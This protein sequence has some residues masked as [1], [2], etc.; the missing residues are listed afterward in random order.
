MF[1]LVLIMSM[2]LII[3]SSA[4]SNDSNG[5][6]SHHHQYCSEGKLYWQNSCSEFEELISECAC[7][8]AEGNSACKTGCTD[9]APDCGTRQ[10]G[11]DGCN[12]S[13]GT[14]G[15][16]LFCSPLDWTCKTESECVTQS[17]KGCYPDVGEGA[18][19]RWFDSCGRAEGIIE[20]C[21]DVHGQCFLD[22]EDRPTCGCFNHWMPM[23]GLEDCDYCP[24]NW[25][26]EQDCNGCIGN[27]DIESNCQT[28][29]GNWSLYHDCTECKNN[30]IDDNNNCGTCPGN[31]DAQ[32]DCAT[33]LGNWDIDQD[34]TV[35]TG[36]WDLAKNCEACS[37]NLDIASNCNTCLKEWFGKH[38]EIPDCDYEEQGCVTIEAGEPGN[39]PPDGELYHLQVVAD[40][41]A[42]F[43]KGQII[44][45][46]VNEGTLNGAETVWFAITVNVES[47]L[48]IVMEMEGVDSIPYYVLFTGDLNE[49]YDYIREKYTF[50]E[51][52]LTY[53]FVADP[54]TVY[55]LAYVKYDGLPGPTNYKITLSAVT[56][57]PS[58]CVKDCE[59]KQ[60][61]SDGCDDTCGQCDE[62]L[63]CSPLDWTCKTESECVTHSY[64][65]CY[66][67]IGEGSDIRWFDSCGRP[68][69]II[70]DC[71]DV[72]GQCYLY[73]NDQPTCGCI[74]H[75]DENFDCETCLP[76]WMGDDCNQ[77]VPGSKKM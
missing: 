34:C 75:W 58:I 32:Q 29:L 46:Y 2:S 33:C 57:L 68:E 9:C 65:G 1:L 44:E 16:G 3:T 23:Y 48:S 18:D 72:H 36:N 60:C 77:I 73:G 50:G 5:C 63:F 53:G 74:N 25:D 67:D 54:N 24:D 27:W 59:N 39:N 30:W 12:G 64:A 70:E 20:D 38:C 13:C 10:C 26:P 51:E 6:T 56:T 7:G 42:L 4:C 19:V 11:S 14:C 61:G 76:G 35:C 40:E 43:I 66:P 8:C 49:W 31:W 69:D 15:D 55:W 71:I 41:P 62:G 37:G 17:Y 28:C 45:T 47:S 52:P 21:A 22:E